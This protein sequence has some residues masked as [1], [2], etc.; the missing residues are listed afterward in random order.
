MPESWPGGVAVDDETLG[1]D[2]DAQ[3][4]AIWHFL[5]LGRSAPTRGI[6]QA[7]L[8]RRRGGHPRST[9]GAAAW[10]GFRGVAV[11]FPEGLHYAFDA[12]NGAL[13]ALWRE[14]FVSVNWNGQGAGDFNPRA[15]ARETR[16]RRRS[17]GGRRARRAWPEARPD[18]GGAG[19][20]R[21][22]LPPPARLP[23]P[24][25]PAL[26]GG[27]RADAALL[28]GR[29]PVS[30]RAVPELE[31]A[32]EGGRARLVRTL[33]FETDAPSEVTFR[34]LAGEVEALEAALTGAA[35]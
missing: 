24:R 3:I 5:T 29:R 18:G 6:D 15:R 1:G 32:D 14:D 8:E 28:P 2:A 4:G 9:A 31:A 13:A 20:P 10:R 34:A 11:G 25:V 19:Q 7:A 12:N 22:D 30:D 23:L 26:R 16:A 21:P 17:P 35:A 33:T 27:R